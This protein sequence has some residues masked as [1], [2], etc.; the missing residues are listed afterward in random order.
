MAGVDIS[1]KAS[2]ASTSIAFES[3]PTTTLDA[4]LLGGVNPALFSANSI[5]LDLDLDGV[6]KAGMVE[7]EEGDAGGG[8]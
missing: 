4:G 7:P 5:I 6:S 3:T 1:S 8:T 2:S